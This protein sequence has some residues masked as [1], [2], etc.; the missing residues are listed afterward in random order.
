MTNSLLAQLSGAKEPWL[1]EADQ[2]PPGYDALDYED[3][4]MYGKHRLF[5]S[6]EN[7]WKLSEFTLFVLI[8][9][10]QSSGE[11][12]AGGAAGGSSK[13]GGGGSGAGGADLQSKE[14]LF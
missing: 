11:S 8:A 4:G 7:R 10:A 14:Q 5:I 6:K 12:T 13:K 1:L 3:L 9:T 2:L